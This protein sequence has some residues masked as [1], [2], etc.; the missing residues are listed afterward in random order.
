MQNQ[1][2]NQNWSWLFISTNQK[3]PMSI[4]WGTCQ[5]SGIIRLPTDE[6]T[7]AQ[8]MFLVLIVSP[9]LSLQV[10]SLSR[11]N[12]PR[13]LQYYVMSCHAM[14]YHLSCLHNWEMQVCAL[15]LHCNMA[16]QQQSTESPFISVANTPINIV[17]YLPNYAFSWNCIQ[18]FANQI[19]EWNTTYSCQRGLEF[20]NVKYK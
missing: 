2:T 5:L 13:C 10:V 7:P 3:P 9:L 18:S 8:K 14:L 12:L 4:W 1:A 20:L 16:S 11:P 15:C 19:H 6:C 17:N